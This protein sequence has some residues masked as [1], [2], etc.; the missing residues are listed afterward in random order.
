MKRIDNLAYILSIVVF[1][2][3]RIVAGGQ[4]PPTESGQLVASWLV[5]IS[6]LYNNQAFKPCRS[7]ISGGLAHFLPRP[8]RLNRQQ[9]YAGHD[10][11]LDLVQFTSTNGPV[12]RA[13][14]PHVEIYPR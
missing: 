5:L 3:R 6:R 9:V 1:S 10:R 13:C 7:P 2:D 4:R 12:P 14:L 8:S 11:I